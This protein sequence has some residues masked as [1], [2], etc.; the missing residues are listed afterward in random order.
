MTTLHAND[1]TVSQ[2]TMHYVMGQ[3]TMHRAN[4]NVKWLNNMIMAQ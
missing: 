3:T 1:N 2:M 4:N